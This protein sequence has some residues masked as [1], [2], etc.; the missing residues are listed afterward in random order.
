MMSSMI[1]TLVMKDTKYMTAKEKER[2]LKAWETF[3]KYGCKRDH[4]TEALYHHL[5]QHCSFIAHYDRGGF[6]AEY[7]ENGDDTVHFLSQFDRSKGA[8]SVEYGELG[9]WLR[10]DYADINN[11][12]IDIAGKYI[13][14]LTTL[15]SG[16]QKER[17]LNLAR[18]ILAKYG[19]KA[20]F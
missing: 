19:M 3:L 14:T 20:E 4:F 18:A 9:Y 1:P 6:Y 7:F 16:K 5:M 13:P 11:A 15:F 12:M 8:K 2:V 10:G 17:D